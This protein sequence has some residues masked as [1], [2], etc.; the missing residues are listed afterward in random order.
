MLKGRFTPILALLVLPVVLFANAG[1]VEVSPIYE[2]GNVTPVQKT[3]ISL[4][5]EILSVRIDGDFLEVD[6]QY[7]FTNSGD[8]E[9]VTIG[10]PVD[11]WYYYP[12]M[13]EYVEEEKESY[14]DFL[15]MRDENGVLKTT[16][17]EGESPFPVYMPNMDPFAYELDSIY[18]FRR[19]YLAEV[20]FPARTEKK[21]RVHYRVKALFYDWGTTKSFVPEYDDRAFIYDLSPA[22]TWGNGTI[23]QIT[24]ILDASRELERGARM[25]IIPFSHQP[26]ESNGI[27]FWEMEDVDVTD[28]EP[29]EIVYNNSR[30]K[31]EELL[32]GLR[33]SIREAE[34]IRV[35]SSGGEGYGVENMFDG[36]L[37]TAWVEGVAGDGVG[38]WIDIKLDDMPYLGVA[39]ANGYI[40]NEEVYYN[41]NRVK[42]I[43]IETWDENGDLMT[44]GEIELRDIEF[45][46]VED[47]EY[48]S[49]WLYYIS[50]RGSSFQKV[51]RIRLTI[52]EVYPGEKF[53]DTCISELYILGDWEGEFDW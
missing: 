48:C 29:V 41:N 51:S 12:E 14:I 24:F 46:S 16:I 18:A 43:Y 20:N 5:E 38:E 19:W 37:S 17:N 2:T 42:T 9:Q 34:S 3:N 31:M 39:I 44:H 1:A 22:S 50:N 13:P 40:K 25:V 27:Y 21:L 36:D 33:V 45:D 28:M 7:S 4:D 35:S 47:R 26:I 52:R 11:F 15:W 10:F 30:A 8:G 32:N 23:D 49:A 53:H 6:V